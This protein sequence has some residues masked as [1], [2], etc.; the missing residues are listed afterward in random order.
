MCVV[1]DMKHS[2]S[3]SLIKPK[4]KSP[5]KERISSEFFWCTIA[6]LTYVVEISHF[7]VNLC[8]FHAQERHLIN[9]EFF[10]LMFPLSASL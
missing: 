10:F 2:L 8:D 4:C 1:N 7:F 6:M 5:W 3:L 9:F